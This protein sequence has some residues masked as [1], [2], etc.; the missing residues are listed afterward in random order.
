MVNWNARDKEILEV[1]KHTVKDILDSSGKPQ[2]ISLRLIK[3]RSRL[4]SFDL[5]LD[6]LPMTK[7]YIHSVIETPMEL[8][9][10]RIRWAIDTLIR[11]GESLSVYKILGMVGV[12]NKYRKAVKAE[13]I[14]QLEL[15]Q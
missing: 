5:Q 14:R 4:K 8:H 3:T 12:G 2:R 13:V 9:K 10:R 6:K 11:E 15:N 7:E 1:V